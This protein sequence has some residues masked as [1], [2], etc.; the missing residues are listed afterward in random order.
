M[1][2]ATRR[3]GERGARQCTK[4]AKGRMMHAVH[5]HAH[6]KHDSIS[7]THSRDSDRRAPMRRQRAH[8][9]AVAENAGRR[10]QIRRAID[11]QETPKWNVDM[12]KPHSR[13]S[14]TG[15]CTAARD[16]R[17]PPF[18]RAG[19]LARRASDDAEAA[20]IGTVSSAT[21]RPRRE[22]CGLTSSIDVTPVNPLKVSFSRLM[23][24]LLAC[25]RESRKWGRARGGES[26]RHAETHCRGV[27]YFQ[28]GRMNARVRKK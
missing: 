5:A 8:A 26:M 6:L 12:K 7:D 3:R 11:A 25:E 10:S 1:R 2:R 15:R 24:K 22:A 23:I 14:S 27:G 20:Q 9:P 28:R 13:A 16:E 4:K 18:A 19:G 17:A 21:T